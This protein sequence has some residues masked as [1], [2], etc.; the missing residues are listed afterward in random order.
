MSQSI[1]PTT[2]K[3]SASTSQNK[4]WKEQLHTIIFEADTPAGKAFDVALLFAI[5]FSVLI[6]MLESVKEIGDRF[7]SILRGL[8]WIFT[9]LFSI[10]YIA[11]LI[12]VKKPLRYALSFMGLVDLLSI[13]PTYLSIIF[14][15]SQSFMVIRTLR[16]LR[17]FRILKLTRFL[18]EAQILKEALKNSRYKIIV[19]L[20]S[21]LSASV[22]VGTLMYLLEGPEYGF[23]SIP[24]SVYWAIV[25]MTTVGYG[26]IAPGTVLGQ[27]LSSI[28]MIIGYGIIAVP[29]GIV[30]SEMTRK[31]STPKIVTT[32]VCS[33]CNAEN[34]DPD[35]LFCKHCGN[36][37]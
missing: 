29:T 22:I 35:A 37:L 18:G 16:L 3:S 2:S 27:F 17:V 10:E 7:G 36:E 32:K 23:S 9:I 30:T 15:G 21:V 8:E 6:I 13:V 31:I 19:F 26:D 34:H 11:R 4:D 1:E 20:V 28:L 5:I 24:R 12:I 25:T 14:V 33:N